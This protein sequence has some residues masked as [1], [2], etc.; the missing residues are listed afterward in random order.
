MPFP[1]NFNTLNM[2]I[3]YNNNCSNTNN[4]QKQAYNPLNGNMTWFQTNPQTAQQA[5]ALMYQLDPTGGALSNQIGQA[6]MADVYSRQ[7]YSGGFNNAGQCMCGR[8]NG[9]QGA[10]LQQYLN[11]MNNMNQLIN[12]L[13][14]SDNVRGYMNN[15][16]I[17]NML[18][19][20]DSTAAL[21]AALMLQQGAGDTGYIQGMVTDDDS[22]IRHW[23]SVKQAM[24]EFNTE[25]DT[26]GDGKADFNEYLDYYIW[27]KEQEQ[28]KTI[29]PGTREYKKYQKE[30]RRLFDAMA[31][32]GT[33]SKERYKAMLTF[34]D[35]QDN[36]RDGKIKNGN[37]FGNA[38]SKIKSQGPDALIKDGKTLGELIG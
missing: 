9:S 21:L 34:F 27:V 31:K 36:E 13:G 10:S 35:K 7:A 8:N 37:F 4:N 26:S 18:N 16:L 19:S 1:F 28:G 2:P 15:A 5:W 22:G 14:L 25:I 32:D 24:K 3:G 12:V 29:S 17:K 23:G 38:I 6:I 11:Y 30:A 33:I 20:G